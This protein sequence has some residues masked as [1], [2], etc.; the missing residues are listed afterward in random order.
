[1][2]EVSIPFRATVLIIDD[3]PDNLQLLFDVLR[4]DH[5]VLTAPSGIEGLAAARQ[6]APDLILLDIMM[7][8]M[9]GFETCRRLKEDTSTATIPV[10]F[11]TAKTGMDDILRGFDLGAVDFVTKPFNIREL[12]AR[13]ATHLDLKFSR[14]NLARLVADKDK[15]FSII[16]HDLRGPIGSFMSITDF[17]AHNVGELTQ[18][19]TK[20]L[21]REMHQT[22]THVYKLLENLLE[23]SQIRLGMIAYH[24]ERVSLAVAADDAIGLVRAQADIKEITLYVDC[25]VIPPVMADRNMLATIMRNLLSNAIKYSHRGGMVEVRCSAAEDDQT[26]VCAI[27]DYGIGI[28]AERVHDVF[29]MGHTRST[30][31]TEKERGSGL[32][33]ILCT[34]L[35]ALH[36]QRLWAESE[37]GK[38]TTVY[39]TLARA[40]RES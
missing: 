17:L 14:E 10:I 15:F 21:L 34:E 31:G 2:S 32:G 3:V 40:D 1:M 35:V 19:E 8:V 16:A 11:L 5:N 6:Y 22:A 24:P 30:Q 29:S 25:R 27:R 33:L 28:T 23:W 38:G 7:P 18:D 12:V 26:V 9:D 36:G 39:F 13:V 20:P 37:L 4:D